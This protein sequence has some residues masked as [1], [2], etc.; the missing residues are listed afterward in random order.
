[1]GVCLSLSSCNISAQHVIMI[2]LPSMKSCTLNSVLKIVPVKKQTV[3]NIYITT[4]HHAL[5]TH[6][7]ITS[8]FFCSSD[9]GLPISFCRWSN[10]IFSTIDRV[11]PSKSDSCKNWVKSRRFMCCWNS[12]VTQKFAVYLLVH[13]FFLF[14]VLGSRESKLTLTLIV[15]H[16]LYNSA[17][18]TVQVRQLQ[19]CICHLILNK[20]SCK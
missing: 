2:L 9:V 4:S 3:Y 14:S 13:H 20:F 1:M 17:S 7:F 6:L 16:F 5:H 15:H 18:L 12:N 8:C 11:S 19:Q 10:I